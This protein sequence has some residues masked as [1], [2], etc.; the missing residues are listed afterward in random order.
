MVQNSIRGALADSHVAAI[1]IAV[2]FFA[3][4][5]RVFGALIYLTNHLVLYLQLANTYRSFHIAGL[6][7]ERDPEMYPRILSC[8]IGA[9]AAILSAWLLSRWIYGVNP[10]RSLASYREKLLRRAHV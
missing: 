4:V 1:T 10:L 6:L 2:L 3:A 7:G 8:I 5:E 9:S